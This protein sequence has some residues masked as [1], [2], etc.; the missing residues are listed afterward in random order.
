[1]A[2]WLGEWVIAEVIGCMCGQIVR[3]APTAD[4]G[5]ELVAAGPKWIPD[6]GRGRPSAN[7]AAALVDLMALVALV[8]VGDMIQVEDAGSLVAAGWES[9]GRCRK[10]WIR[11]RP[12]R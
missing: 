5:P 7:S 12:R 3:W 4:H 11:R 10:R 9:A 2:G 6:R 1:M 8:A